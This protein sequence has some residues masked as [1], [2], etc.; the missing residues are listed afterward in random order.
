MTVSDKEK[1]TP[2][3]VLAGQVTESLVKAGFVSAAK[4]AEV[5]AKVQSGGASSEDWLLWIEL[6]QAEKAKEA[7]NVA[8]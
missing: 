7:V 6:A 1:K 5:L 4:A 8:S 3:E 2:N